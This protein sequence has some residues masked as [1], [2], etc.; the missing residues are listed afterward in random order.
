MGL[1]GDPEHHRELVGKAPALGLLLGGW[2]HLPLQST[3]LA[4][5]VEGDHVN[6]NL[7]VNFR[8]ALSVRR[9]HSLAN[10]SLDGLVVRYALNDSIRPPGG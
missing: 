2:H 1:L 10:I 4:L 6:P 9:A 3:S 8:H 5:I 7:L